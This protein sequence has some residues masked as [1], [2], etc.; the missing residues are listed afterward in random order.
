MLPDVAFLRIFGFYVELVTGKNLDRNAAAISDA[1]NSRSPAQNFRNGIMPAITVSFLG[2][3]APP[4]LRELWIPFLG[5]P[6]L[7]SSATDLVALHLLNIPNFG[8]ISLAPE[9]I[10]SG[11][12]VLTGLHHYSPTS[13][14]PY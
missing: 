9:E 11:L 6:N 3:S 4:R 8:Y 13:R 7:L 1:N 10:V 2:G 12:S 14:S 5:L